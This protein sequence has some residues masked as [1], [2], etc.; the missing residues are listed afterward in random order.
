MEVMLQPLDINGNVIPQIDRVTWASSSPVLTAS[1]STLTGTLTVVSPST[2]PGDALFRVF[3]NGTGADFFATVTSFIE[4]TFTLGGRSND[5]GRGPRMVPR[6]RPSPSCPS[7][8][9]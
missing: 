4:G 1:G 2:A 6:R 5:T 9:S 3:V 7:K 8:S